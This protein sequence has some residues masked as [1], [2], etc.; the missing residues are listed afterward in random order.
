M[1]RTHPKYQRIYVNGYDLSGQTRSLGT[2]GNTYQ[3]APD[4]ALSDGVDNVVL[5]R[6][7][8]QCGPLNAFL[9]PKAAGT[10]GL[11]ELFSAFGGP[12]YIMAVLGTPGGP[13]AGDP[14]FMAV[15]E[16][17]EYTGQPVD[18]MFPVNIAFPGPSS[19]GPLAYSSPFGVLVAPSA[20][21]TATNAGN[22]PNVNNGAATTKGGIFWYHLL[23]SDGTVTLSLDDSANGTSWT[24]LS[25]ATSGSITA[26]VSPKYGQVSLATTATVRQYLRWQ[27]TLGTAN[28]FT[29]VFGFIRG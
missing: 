24:A 1:S 21:R 2:L 5:G 28:T 7:S 27:A 19:Q 17:G 3:D 20:A 11:H 14:A 15:M 26:A 23:S 29:A 4:A 10:T 25:G 16:Q 13:S 9:D 22:T 12:W 8:V 18:G 6:A